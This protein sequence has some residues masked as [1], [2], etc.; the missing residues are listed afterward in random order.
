VSCQFASERSELA[1]GREDLKEDLEKVIEQ[2]QEATREEKRLIE[3]KGRL[4]QREVVIAEFHEK[5]KAYNAMLDGI[6][7]PRLRR[8]CRSCSRSLMTGLAKYLLLRKTSRRRMPPWRSGQRVSSDWRRISPGGR[9][10]GK[11]G[12]NCWPSTS[13]RQRRRRRIWRSGSAGSRWRRQCR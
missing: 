2:E 8:H 1:H 7:R 11:G 3:R 6:S 13:S 4:D 9:R 10:C 12:I 5:L